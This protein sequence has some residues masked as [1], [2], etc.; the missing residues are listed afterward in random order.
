MIGIMDWNHH[1]Y[2]G[3]MWPTEAVSVARVTRHSTFNKKDS[4]RQRNVRQFLQ[5]A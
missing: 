5:S 2:Q 4:Y 3:R 1:P